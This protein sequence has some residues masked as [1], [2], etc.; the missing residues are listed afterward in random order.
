MGVTFP[1]RYASSQASLVL[2]GPLNL[3]NDRVM[4]LFS[5]G[6]AKLARLCSLKKS[7]LF[8]ACSRAAAARV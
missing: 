6:S 2:E 1:V 3:L 7:L 4:A 5:A 8:D